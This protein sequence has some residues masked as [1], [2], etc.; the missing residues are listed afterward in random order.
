MSTSPFQLLNFENCNLSLGKSKIIADDKTYDINWLLKD[1]N[2]F[3][4]ENEL[5]KWQLSI[6]NVGNK[7]I[8]STSAQLLTQ[9]KHLHY[10]IIE[11]D[12]IPFEHIL[13]S[14]MKMGGCKVFTSPEPE[15]KK[16]DAFYTLSL[17]K[18]NNTLLISWPLN[19]SSWAKAQGKVK[20]N[21]LSL[22]I[23]ADI[24]H[25]S[26]LD[27]S[28]PDITFESGNGITLLQNYANDNIEN[29]KEIPNAVPGWNTWDYYRW[30]ITEEEVLKNA[31]FIAKD[32]ILSQHIKRIIIDDGWQY[33]Y[34]EWHANS[35]FPSGTKKLANEI[36]KLNFT[37]GIWVAPVCVEPHA[38][39][40]QL[41]YDMLAW[42]EGGQPTLAFDCMRRKGFVI[43]P[44][45]EKS[46][47]FLKDLFDRLIKDGYEY[48]KLDFLAAVLDA[49][50]YH[51]AS[52]PRSQIMRVLMQSIN[53]GVDNRAT[54]MGCNYPYMA[55]N[56]F[57]AAS[58]VGGDIH[59]DW[60]CIKSNTLSVA[61]RF[62]M[63]RKLWLNDPDFA[64]CRGV[65]T[66][67]YPDT[68]QPVLVF[69]E[70]GM[71]Y[72]PL[73]EKTFSS[74]TEKE[75]EILLSIVLM[76]AGAVNLS[77]DLTKLNEHGLELARKVVSAEQGKTAIPLDLFSSKLPSKWQQE[78]AH[79]GRILLVNWLDEAQ[80]IKVDIPN[81]PEKATNFWTGK[82]MTVPKEIEL[83]PRSCLLLQY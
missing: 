66:T 49:R 41:D 73:A 5:G 19:L 13:S 43:D 76:A 80:I 16:F 42:N 72:H 60:G 26:N 8:V 71:E 23:C 52:I 14:S 82:T 48:F 62:W 20:D 77:D 6:K 11:C 27:I 74:A 33:C 59:S 57:V 7:T 51:D 67:D 24:D 39:I 45:V 58:R 30:T 56:K 17:S 29:K 83:A 35:Y 46:K 32:P 37:P 70:P 28:F 34:G 38:R 53:E 40:A 47:K 75:L 61:Y 36:K 63:N 55:G 68:L 4:S 9:V 78:L 12:N 3:Y 22:D 31:E 64:V 65:D 1:D 69:C 2:N 25:Y 18:N 54:I 79:G 50:R 15:E 21:I 44:T 10:S 81:L